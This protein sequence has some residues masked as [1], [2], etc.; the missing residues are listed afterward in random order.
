[1][2][3]LKTYEGLFD[4]FK[5]KKPLPLP[6]HQGDVSYNDIIDCLLYIIDENKITTS[7]NNHDSDFGLFVSPSDTIKTGI[8]EEQ[9]GEF[10]F[11]TSNYD[12]L[13]IMKYSPK[14]ISDKEV[15]SILDDVNSHLN[16]YGC[17][18]T[19]YI[20]WGY[21]EGQTSD[22]EWSDFTK[23]L[24]KTIGLRDGVAGEMTER[25]IT[26]RIKSPNVLDKYKGE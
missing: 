2:K 18:M 26:V 3:Y 23:M 9:I 12:L 15:E 6:L 25:H 19:F 10:K 24:N 22:D 11:Y 21:D 17:K 16:G 8:W 13:F 7:L 1:M 5:R 4:I 20:G 14:E